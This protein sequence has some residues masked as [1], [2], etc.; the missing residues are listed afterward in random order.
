MFISQV[1]ISNVNILIVD[2]NQKVW[3]MGNNYSRKMGFGKD[4]HSIYSPM[5][6]G[7]Q[8]GVEETV[9]KFIATDFMIIIYTSKGNVYIPN[10]IFNDVDLD[11]LDFKKRRNRNAIMP[12]VIP[13]IPALPRYE[14]R[15]EDRD[16]DRFV[17][18]TDSDDGIPKDCFA[19]PIRNGDDTIEDSE[20]R[21]DDYGDERV[22]EIDDN[23]DDEI[24]DEIE[25]EINP[26][27]IPIYELFRAAD[28]HDMLDSSSE[29]SEE[30]LTDP[31][32]ASIIDNEEFFYTVF[33]QRMGRHSI[34]ST[35]FVLFETDVDDIIAY[36]KVFIFRKKDKLFFYDPSANRNDYVFNKKLGMSCVLIN[37][38]EYPYYQILPPFDINSDMVFH[39]DFVMC[40][41]FDSKESDVRRGGMIHIIAVKEAFDSAFINWIYFKPD[42]VIDEVYY[43]NT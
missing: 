2:S 4:S 23:Y 17:A 22:D 38:P 6:I 13:T 8:L 26:T 3:L 41:V 35:G 27:N 5:Y 37:K 19:Q 43:L 18:L 15:D 40:Q 30:Q 10:K 34:G 42:F 32:M 20:E 16:E 29:D 24:D 21:D 33:D 28:R 1:L 7:L 9:K 12:T 14:D 31:N 36:S 11:F 25:D 39:S